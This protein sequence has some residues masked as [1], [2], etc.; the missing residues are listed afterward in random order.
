MLYVVVYYQE[1]Y[2][3]S[4]LE[5]ALY[6]G[7]HRFG[8]SLAN[9]WLVLACVMGYG[10]ILKKFLSC[11]ALVPFSRLTYC[12]YLT[13]GF[14]ELYLLSSTRSPKHMSIISLVSDSLY[15]NEQLYNNN[16]LKNLYKILLFT[17]NYLVFFSFFLYIYRQVMH[18]LTSY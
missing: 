1:D 9:G 6:A 14:V 8:W 17:N 11:R 3:Y 4:V 13:N 2:K 18:L 15:K 12:A 7:L 10:G 5:A 16:L